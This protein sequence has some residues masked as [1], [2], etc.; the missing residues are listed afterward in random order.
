[1]SL[2]PGWLVGISDPNLP[3]PEPMD[4]EAVIDRLDRVA[5]AGVVQGD[6]TAMRALNPR[7][8]PVPVPFDEDAPIRRFSFAKEL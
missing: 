4:E 1:M 7:P 2:R 5:P 8:A 3:A 6:L